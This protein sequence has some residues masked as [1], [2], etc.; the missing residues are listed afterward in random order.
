MTW[1]KFRTTEKQYFDLS[2]EF[3][4]LLEATNA[5]LF[6]KDGYAWVVYQENT[7]TDTT[8]LYL[9]TDSLFIASSMKEKLQDH[10]TLLTPPDTLNLVPVFGGENGKQ[11]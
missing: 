6:L 11:V 9:K 3:F 2:I 8:Y 10:I 7:N 5:N 4:P 1:F